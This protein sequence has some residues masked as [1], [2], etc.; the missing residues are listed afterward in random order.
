MKLHL[1]KHQK[2]TWQCYIVW[3]QWIFCPNNWLKQQTVGGECQT[4]MER[5]STLLIEPAKY[6][7]QD[8]SIKEFRER[9]P[10][11]VMQELKPPLGSQWLRHRVVVQLILA[12]LQLS[13]PTAELNICE[14]PC[15]LFCIIKRF[16]STLSFKKA[17]WGTVH[18][19]SPEQSPELSLSS[20]WA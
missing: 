9:E 11:K 3:T 20:R 10:V 4:L 12:H 8:W 7:P 15:S 6:I 17:I 19:Q 18:G 1:R 16:L 14:V 13:W 2:N 5:T